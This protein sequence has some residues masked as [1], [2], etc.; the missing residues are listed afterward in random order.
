MVP[1]LPRWIWSWATSLPFVAGAVNADALLTLHKG[2]VTH[3][4]GMSTEAAAGIAGT[5]VQLLTNAA[6]VIGLFTMGCALSA[7]CIK[8]DRWRP[9]AA[10][11]L[12]FV[13]ES[14]SLAV[15]GFIIDAHPM[16][17]FWLCA[18]AIGLQNGTT[19]LVTGAVLRTS[20]L[21]G[22]FTDLGTAF[23]QRVRGATFDSGRAKVSV[24]V[25][26]SFVSGA[27]ASAYVHPYAPC[28]GI[29][30]PCAL[31]LLNAAMT[32]CCSKTIRPI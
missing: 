6:T 1:V 8:A 17:A 25:I 26:M 15:A 30:I 9:S 2:G 22:M 21:T 4:T 18:F 10:A 27:T 31:V 13:L 3:L 24:V 12:M 11:A 32:F 23:G 20:H 7:W 16:H 28:L 14:I 29:I 19:S 5:D